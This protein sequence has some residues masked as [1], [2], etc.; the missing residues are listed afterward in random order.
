MQ[1]QRESQYRE[2]WQQ[3]QRFFEQHER[4]LQQQRRMERWRF[5]QRYWERQRQDQIRLQNFR[6]YDYGYPNYRY[7]REGR[8]FETNQYGADLL[9]RALNNGYEEGFRAIKLRLHNDSKWEAAVSVSQVFGLRSI[10]TF[11]DY[12]ERLLNTRKPLDGDDAR[13]TRWLPNAI[14]PASSRIIGL[15]DEPLTIM[16]TFGVLGSL[17]VMVNA[18]SAPSVFKVLNKELRIVAIQPF[19]PDG[20]LTVTSSAAKAAYFASMTGLT[21]AFSIGPLAISL[22]ARR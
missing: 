22:N 11:N 21:L 18:A 15:P 6:Y 7:Y 20:E 1:R 12:R 10:C 8:Y 5:E 9:R 19:T 13:P 3:Q 4:Q 16:T 17:L 2:R 14:D